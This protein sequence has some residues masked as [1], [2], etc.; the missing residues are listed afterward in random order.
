MKSRSRSRAA[1]GSVFS[2]SMVPGNCVGGLSP[3]E[4]VRSGPMQTERPFDRPI[5]ADPPGA[6]R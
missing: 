4:R 3:R 1:S 2:R 6:R 5:A